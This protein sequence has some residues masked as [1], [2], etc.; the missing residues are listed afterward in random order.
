[1]L[2]IEPVYDPHEPDQIF[3]YLVVDEYDIPRGNY[4][5]YNDARD[6]ISALQGDTRE[7][8]RQPNPVSTYYPD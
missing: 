8:R 6:A 5:S 7:A 4:D 1:M 2:T 3:C